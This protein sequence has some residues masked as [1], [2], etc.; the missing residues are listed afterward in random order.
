MTV[1]KPRSRQARNE[2]TATDYWLEPCAAYFDDL[3]A[4]AKNA[5]RG[6]VINDVEAV[7]NEQGQELLRQSL[8]TLL[9]D[10]IDDI[11]KKRKQVT[12]RNAPQRNATSDTERKKSS[13]PKESSPL[14]DATK[15]VVL[16]AFPNTSLMTFSDSMRGTRSG[17]AVL[18]FALH[19]VCKFVKW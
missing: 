11:E 2:Q 8:E 7:A 4:S 5:S 13:P 19:E 14:Y 18:S 10:E 1:R 16:V 12:V 6:Q 3:K 17:Y 9:Q 15:N